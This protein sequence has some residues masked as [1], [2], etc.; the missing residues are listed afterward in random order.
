MAINRNKFVTDIKRIVNIDTNQTSLPDAP[1]RNS[2]PSVSGI[3]F[4]TT[5]GA[6]T[7]AMQT[8][9]NEDLSNLFDAFFAGVD[10][11]TT[12]TGQKTDPTDP[13]SKANTDGSKLDPKKPNAIPYLDEEGTYDIQDII[14]GAPGTPVAPNNVPAGL[15][16][17]PT[18]NGGTLNGIT[19]AVD[20]DSG[21][22]IDL[23]MDKLIKPPSNWYTAGQAAQS[24]MD[25]GLGYLNWTAG[26]Q[27]RGSSISQPYASFPLAAAEAARDESGSSAYTEMVD[28]LGDFNFPHTGGLT[29]W[30]FTFKRPSLSGT[31]QY[32]A[33]D[34][35]C[36]PGSS[37]TCPL[38][39][40]IKWPT[41]NKMQLVKNQD[42][43]FKVAQYE[44]PD[45][46]IPKFTDDIHSR[47]DFCFDS[48]RKG[49]ILPAINGAYMI[50][51][52]DSE[53][54]TPEGTVRLYD[55]S[56]KLEAFLDSTN[57]VN[58]LPK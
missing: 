43:T 36:T 3:A 27:W 45:D 52:T 14:D 50:T 22:A 58:Y 29:R 53:G 57:Y 12:D 19:G 15:A 17:T 32:Y 39:N 20:C 16:G 21:K 2:I 46:I 47:V 26:R 18:R 6:N 28:V 13:N 56:N 4:S 24:D 42:G 9:P 33:F 48:G 35:T 23:R 44:N 8:Q 49:S 37:G 7:K 30:I 1:I 41:D 25:P 10:A 31:V 38:V 5:D 11:G 34:V 54:G 51:E 55:S 40:P